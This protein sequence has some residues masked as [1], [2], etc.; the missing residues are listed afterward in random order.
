MPTQYDSLASDYPDIQNLPGAAIEEINVHAAIGSV[1]G[2]RCLDLACGDGHFSRLLLEWGANEVVG[3]DISQAM[4]EQ[5]A[6]LSRLEISRGQLRLIKSDVS[7]NIDV[8]GEFDIILASWLLNYA[9]DQETMNDMFRNIQS[10][11][12]AGGKFVGLTTPPQS[13]TRVDVE[14]HLSKNMKYGCW[15]H[16]TKEIEAG[17]QVHNVLGTGGTPIVEIDNFY[18]RPEVYERA[19]T[20]NNLHD[21]EWKKVFATDGLKATYGE[22]FWDDC[23][24]DPHFAVF[25]ASK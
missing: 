20:K 21:C 22:A 7:K 11:L 15:G 13:G 1:E 2:V 25:S 6:K 24:E 4:L 3:A 14:A 18:L 16:V 23:V 19:A 8:D 17:F 12:K 5:A 9:P 10:K